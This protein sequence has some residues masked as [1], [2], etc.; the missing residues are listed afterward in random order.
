MRSPTR[1][2]LDEAKTEKDVENAY[3]AEIAQ[4][5]PNAKI[6]SPFGSDGFVEFETV[7]L[8]LEAK[9]DWDMKHKTDSC[10]ALGQLVFYLKKFEKA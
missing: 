10:K 1:R 8:L 4:C 5:L 6:T 7:R 3:R 2:L 9:Y